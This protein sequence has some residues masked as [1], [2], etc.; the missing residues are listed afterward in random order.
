MRVFFVAVLLIVAGGAAPLVW[1]R[2]AAAMRTLAV[3]TMALGCLIGGADAAAKLFA[4]SSVSVTVAFLSRFELAFKLDPL[5]A[6]FLM[7]VFA[8][9]LL[10]GVYSFHYL[11]TDRHPLRTA[12]HYFLL[13]LL[14]AAMALVV[15]ADNI[16]AFALCWELMSL[17]SLGLVLHD[18]EQ[19]PNRKAAYLYA[20]FSHVG[21]LAILA[22]FA[23]IYDHTGAF[24]FEAAADLPEKTKIWVFV[25][26]FLG[27][28]SKAGIFP[29][30]IWLPHAH[31]AAPSHVSALMSGVML[32]IGIYGILRLY[33]V[34]D[35]HT[36]LAGRLVLI[37]G[38]ISGIL[39]VI[40]ALGQ[41]DLKRLLAY[42]SMENVG[43]ILMGLG[44]GMI[45]VAGA[46]PIMAVL[47]FAGALWHVW[48]HAI[49]KSL[50]F[51]GAGMVV[52]HTGTRTLDLLGGLARRMP[53]TTAAFGIGALAICAVPPLNG[54]A[55]EFFIYLGGFS[56]LAL[57]DTDFGLSIAAIVSLAL[58]GALALAV[59]SKALGIVF[60][61]EPRSASAAA[62]HEQGVCMW[63]PMLALAA[64]C[65][66]IGVFPGLVLPMV[67]KAVTALGLGYGRIPLVPFADLTAAIARAALLL[68]AVVALL[69]ALRKWLYRGKP[70]TTAGTWGC[71]F[72]RPTARMQYTGASYADSILTFFR[73]VAPL[74]EE[75]PAIRGRF[76]DR[77]YYISH[78]Q[79]L[80]ERHVGHLVVRPVQR[81]FDRL[82]WVQHGDIHMYIGFILIAI[83]VA[84]VF[85]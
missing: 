67:L 58:I 2:R 41:H 49:F 20:V 54:F 27:F 48:N 30:H 84:L 21:V 4:P 18:Y 70:V 50:L 82:R 40:Y 77:T 59:F 79:D 11:E 3:T 76:P 28:G 68:T 55:S 37:A 19:G 15:A 75:H 45:G 31:P 38:L 35:W 42:S 32:K 46:K 34:L 23:L 69:L 73:A 1:I 83:V 66:L 74:G 71:G 44:I 85:I 51:M 9:G 81:F 12:L 22:S 16:I 64:A 25:L 13:A 39:G 63:I 26:A 6:F 62:A 60:L 56:G 65:V 80:A 57:I 5:S 61:G 24:G 43:I 47:G 7:A 53:I 72:T 52:H 78:I 10:A 17:S 29:L 14:L 8:I 36:P 33:A